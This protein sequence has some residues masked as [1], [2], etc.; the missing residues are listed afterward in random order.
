MKPLIVLIG[1]L[2]LS[3]VISKFINK[4]IDIQLAGRIAMT[5]MLVFTAIGHFAFTEG[6]TAMIPEFI[7]FKKEIIVT[8]GILEIFFGIALLFSNYQIIIGWMII[9]FFILIIPANIKASLGNINYQTG[10]SN[11]PG[12]SYLWLRIPM[13]ILFIVWVYFSAIKK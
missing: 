3:I 10:E 9:V 2:I 7:P 12:L 11:G 8:T 1:T 4:Q 5:C 13:Q 6:M